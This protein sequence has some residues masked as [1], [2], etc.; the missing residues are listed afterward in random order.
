MILKIRN[1]DPDKGIGWRLIDKIENVYYEYMSVKDADIM[2]CNEKTINP[3]QMHMVIF[4]FENET[5]SKTFD[6]KICLIHYLRNNEW[7]TISTDD[8]IYILNNN[9]KTVDSIYT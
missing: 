3:N 2:M 9:G 4:N 1:K 6:D 5:Q 8:T 7:C